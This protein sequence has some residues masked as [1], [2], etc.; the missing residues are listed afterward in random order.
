MKKLFPDS[1]PPRNDTKDTVASSQEALE[2]ARQLAHHPAVK[3]LF[4]AGGPEQASTDRAHRRPIWSS[5]TSKYD[6]SDQLPKIQV[7]NEGT[8][9]LDATIAFL[10]NALQKDDRLSPAPNPSGQAFREALASHPMWGQYPIYLRPKSPDQM[11]DIHLLR[12]AQNWQRRRERLPAGNKDRPRRVAD[13]PEEKRPKIYRAI[14][15]QTCQ[16]Q[17]VICL[18]WLNEY[19]RHIVP[20]PDC[21]IKARERRMKEAIN[22][23]WQIDEQNLKLTKMTWINNRIGAVATDEARAAQQEIIRQ[24]PSQKTLFLYGVASVGKTR[25]LAEIALVAR[26]RGLSSILKTTKRIQEIIQDFPLQDDPPLLR[27]EK[28]RRLTQAR[29]DLKNV[30]VLLIDELDDVTGRYFQGELLEILNHRLGNE[31]TTCFAANARKYERRN[32]NG[33]VVSRNY[34]LDFL[35]DPIRERLLAKG[36]LHVNLCQDK[37]LRNFVGV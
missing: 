1:T 22:R 6:R 31:L 15:C 11:N 9:G 28:Q 17:Q 12:Q 4:A 16:D 23:R 30:D 2:L 20:C 27:A 5:A 18:G 10:Q 21:V 14:A 36:T 26:Q 34:T 29:Q 37:P 19:R 8:K 3:T 35:T 13:L 32:Q 24:M 33:E 7:P 25:L